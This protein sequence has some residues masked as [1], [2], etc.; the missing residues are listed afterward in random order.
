MKY[1]VPMS[2]T[3]KERL[4]LVDLECGDERFC[5]LLDTGAQSS[6]LRLAAA[7]RLGLEMDGETAVIPEIRLGPFVWRDFPVT[8]DRREDHSAVHHGRPTDGLFG[9]DLM[10][11]WVWLYE[12]PSRV[13]HVCSADDPFVAEWTRDANRLAIRPHQLAG[14]SGHVWATECTLDGHGPVHTNM[15][16]GAQRTILT[17]K[18]GALLDPEAPREAISVS[19]GGDAVNVSCYRCHARTIEIAG[20]RFERPLVAVADPIFQVAPEL[21]AIPAVLLG[22][23]VYGANSYGFDLESGVFWLHP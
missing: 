17:S 11:G 13:L 20:V 4:N 8:L 7:E 21:L 14:A 1:S 22:I 12:R 5:V 16:T 6:H 3:P 2:P 10:N 18:A 19:N 15:D 23:D 9:T